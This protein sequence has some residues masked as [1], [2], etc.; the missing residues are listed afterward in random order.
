MRG[1]ADGVVSVLLPSYLTAIGFSSLRVG[2]IVFG[3]LIGS[4]VLTPM[5]RG[6]TSLKIWNLA[7]LFDL[8]LLVAQFPRG[9]GY[10]SI[11]FRADR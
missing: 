7:G 2:A 11:G 4:A 10:A 3:T 6:W 9:A 8:V 5:D 1:F